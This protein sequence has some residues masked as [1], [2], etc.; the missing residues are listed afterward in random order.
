MQGK[1]HGRAV[2]CLRA[3]MIEY[4]EEGATKELFKIMLD[5]LMY[6]ISAWVHIQQ[7]TI[8]IIYFFSTVIFILFLLSWLEL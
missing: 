8:A 3:C 5:D 4:C 2:P 1:I 7:Q 6:Y